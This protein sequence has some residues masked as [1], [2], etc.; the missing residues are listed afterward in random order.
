MTKIHKKILVV[1]G[2][3]FIGSHLTQK[4]V[5]L[6]YD[7]CV[8]DN[9]SNIS[10]IYNNK[11][12]KQVYGDIS[13]IKD[14]SDCVK[15]FKPDIMINLAAY[16]YIP[17]CIKDPEKTIRVNV[18]GTKNSLESIHKFSPNTKFLITSSAAV[19][20]PDTKKHTEK[21][22]IGPIEIYGES[23]K[24]AENVVEDY[25]KK[26]NIKYSILRLFNVY[27]YGNN[28]PH[29]IPTIIDQIKNKKTISLGNI[30]TKRDYIY[31]DSVVNAFIEIINNFNKNSNKIFNVGSGLASS[32]VDIVNIIENKLSN[33]KK[34]TSKKIII[35]K[36]KVRIS[37]RPL[38]LSDI[39]KIK[40]SLNWKPISLKS[41]L[42]KLIKKEGLIL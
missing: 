6:K 26:F 18:M 7:V 30:N 21:S 25:A 5:S 11:L 20:K 19:Y 29:L 16:H 33:D 15:E 37:D 38:L 32:A 1:G 39:S 36:S 2:A 8:F 12:C 14:I 42:N 22:L 28:T 24:M 27:G 10:K 13:N 41:G 31:V 35:N 34:Y 17:N 40:K 3:G 9:L 23:K 4:L